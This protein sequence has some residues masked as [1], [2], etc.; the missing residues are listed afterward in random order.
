MF[1]YFDRL[2]VSPLFKYVNTTIIL[3]TYVKIIHLFLFSRVI[4]CMV[5][6]QNEYIP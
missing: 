5:E 4:V 2:M 6:H 1:G 3:A